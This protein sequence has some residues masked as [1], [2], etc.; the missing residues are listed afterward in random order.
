MLRLTQADIGE[1]LGIS[2]QSVSLLEAGARDISIDECLALCQ[3]LQ[4]TL[5]ELLNGASE[6]ELRI[7]GI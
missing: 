7:L 5:R 3:L 2:R 1:A 6:E 4:C